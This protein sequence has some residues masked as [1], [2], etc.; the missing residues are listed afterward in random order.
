MEETPPST[1]AATTMLPEVPPLVQDNDGS[2]TSSSPVLVA[3]DASHTLQI[4]DETQSFTQDLLPYMQDKWNLASCGFDYNVVAVFGSQSTGKSTL[5]NR[6]FSTSFTVMDEKQRRQ[7]TKGIWLSPAASKNLLVLDV[8]GTDGR[9][10]GEDQDFERKS[11]LFSLAVAEVLIVNMWEHMVGLYNGANM[12]LLKTVFEVNLQLFQAQGSPKTLLMFILRDFTGVTPL[13]T[14]AKTLIQDLEK[15]WA[16][17]SKPAGHESSKISDFFDF[18]FE[19]LPHK[20]FA[21]ERFDQSIELLRKRFYESRNSKY[22]FASHYHKHI[23]A[24]GF[25]R[26]AESIWAKILTNRDLDLPTQQQLLA[27]YRCDEIAR[28]VLE[29]FADATKTYRPRLD[30]GVVIESIGHET[31][32]I[33]ASCLAS[34]DKDASRYNAD[35]Y[36]RK[37]DE[38]LDKLTSTLHINYIE[39]LRNLHKQ[40]TAQFNKSLQEKL[41]N[42]DAQFAATLRSCREEAETTFKELAIKSR[43]K[44]A[45][46]SYEEFV[47]QFHS[48]L[49]EIATAKRSDAL[50]RMVS[51]LQKMILDGLSEPIVKEL[52][53]VGPDMWNRISLTFEGTVQ[54]TLDQVRIKS[55]GFEASDEEIKTSIVEM[56]RQAWHVLHRKLVEETDLSRM[57]VR[58]KTFFEDKFKYDDKGLPRIWKPDDDIDGIFTKARSETD[59]LYSRFERICIPEETLTEIVGTIDESDLVLLSPS[60]QAMLRDRFRREEDAA[61]LDVKRSVVSTTAHIPWWMFLVL[62]TLGWNEIIFVLTNPFYLMALI[63]G[64]LLVVA[65]YYTGTLGPILR[66]GQMASREIVFQIASYLRDS[67]VKTDGILPPLRSNSTSYSSDIKTPRRVGGTSDVLPTT[68]LPSKTPLPYKTPAAASFGDS[69]EEDS[70][71]PMVGSLPSTPMGSRQQRLHQQQTTQRARSVWKEGDSVDE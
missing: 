40:G 14:L 31:E 66:V 9:E 62:L 29:T 57:L 43:I 10:R 44:F 20:I 37:R 38:F 42:G 5:L 19:G 21:A 47:S 58:L 18:A 49:D 24:D 26:Y 6:L 65:M 55:K 32:A 27:Q 63:T 39:Q 35:V 1:A 33:V 48:A 41:K 2:P 8:E 69:G 16:G 12:G 46:W 13:E 45:D 25:P 17:L 71:T 60:K 11:A 53:D 34:F 70:D 68:P 36:K 51:G 59:I 50:Q 22:L 23:P 30:A 67:G 3:A 7:T 54:K 56:Q 15:I 4:V 52:N 28:T 61:Y 64:A